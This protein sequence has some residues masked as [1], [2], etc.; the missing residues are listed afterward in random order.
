MSHPTFLPLL[1]LGAAL[2]AP[3]AQAQTPVQNRADRRADR[4]QGG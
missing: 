2:L 3:L 4:R 1:A